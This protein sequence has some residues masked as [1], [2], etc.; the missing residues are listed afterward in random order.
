MGLQQSTALEQLLF[1]EQYCGEHCQRPVLGTGNPAE[2]LKTGPLVHCKEDMGSYNLPKIFIKINYFAN[3]WNYSPLVMYLYTHWGKW[4]LKLEHF[5]WRNLNEDKQ[6]N[7][8]QMTLEFFPASSACSILAILP[9]LLRQEDRSLCIYTD[10]CARSYNIYNIW[11]ELKSET[12]AVDKNSII[13]VP[14]L[15]LSHHI[16][17]VF[18]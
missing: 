5:D 15:L 2:P 6:E 18:Y 11:N 16:I 8:L 10:I 13:K 1:V 14:F 4:E 3:Y 17:K 12:T 9:H 7:K